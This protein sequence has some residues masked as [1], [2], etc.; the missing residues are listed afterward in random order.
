MSFTRFVVADL[1]IDRQRTNP[2]LER[3]SR[4]SRS[5]G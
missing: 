2:D 5:S 3:R 4:E 1:S